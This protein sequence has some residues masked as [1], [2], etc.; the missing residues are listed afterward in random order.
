MMNI[1]TKTKLTGFLKF[2]CNFADW[3]DLEDL[4]EMYD[5]VVDGERDNFTRL[6]RLSRQYSFFKGLSKQTEIDNIISLMKIC[7]RLGVDM[8][9]LQ[10]DFEN[11]EETYD[12]IWNGINEQVP[13][14]DE[15]AMGIVRI[16]ERVMEEEDELREFLND[17]TV[18]DVMN[19]CSDIVELE[20]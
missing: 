13:M 10:I 14:S 17:H 9:Q 7:Q 2:I 4:Q 5:E 8:P 12:L 15:M 20:I 3:E 11:M 18:D 16:A 1:E 19:R 6:S